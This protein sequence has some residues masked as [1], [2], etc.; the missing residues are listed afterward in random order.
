ME[1]STDPVLKP[2][3]YGRQTQKS[4][5]DLEK[6]ATQSLAK[7]TSFVMNADMK[8]IRMA[9]LVILKEE[10]KFGRWSRDPENRLAPYLQANTRLA[11]VE[12]RKD[13]RRAVE[14]PSAT[15][16]AH[17]P[18]AQN[19]DIG[20]VDDAWLPQAQLQVSLRLSPD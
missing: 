17:A 16:G 10:D 4:K 20:L 7:S 11:A 19:S 3:P 1:R 15:T 9:E 14:Q 6:E 13:D 18:H 12:L 5:E 8:K 2:S